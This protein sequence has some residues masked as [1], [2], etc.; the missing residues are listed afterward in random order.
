LALALTT[1][2]LAACGAKSD[3]RSSQVVATVNDKE[4]TVTQLDMVIRSTGAREV[5]PELTKQAL[6]SLTSEELLVQ[7]AVSNKI[8]RDPAFVQ[9]MEHSR[10]QLLAQFF[11]ERNLYPKSIITADEIQDYYKS[12]P[13]L[14]ADR[15][16]FRLTTFVADKGD[17][18][19]S[20]NAA[21]QGVGSVDQVRTVLDGHAIKY[22]TQMTSVAPEQ[23]PLNELEAFKAAKVG[24]LFINERNG[25]KVVLMTVTAIEEEVPIPIDRAKP[26]IEEYLKNTRN[27]QAAEAYLKEAKATAKIS[28]LGAAAAAVQASPEHAADASTGPNPSAIPEKGMARLE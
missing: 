7:A 15:K 11:A 20:V 19:D 28:Y 23:L 27:R 21:L 26:M 14:F 18:T 4:I 8:D 10:R 17:M 3:S 13:L 2:T 22:V 12:Q 1:A 16:K 6:D 25:G 5:T 24:D 9:A